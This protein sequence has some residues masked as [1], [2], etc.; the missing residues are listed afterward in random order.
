MPA[1]VTKFR[2]PKAK[3]PK[4][5]WR[6]GAL[7]IFVRDGFYHARGT[8]RHAGLKRRVRASLEIPYSREIPEAAK[9]AARDLEEKIRGELGGGVKP[10]SAAEVALGFMTRP[11]DKPLGATDIAAVKELVRHFGTRILRDIAPAEFITFVDERQKG[12]TSSGRERYLNAVHAL[13]NEAIRKGQ[14]PKM[15]AFNRDKAARNP[16]RRARRKVANVRP[17]LVSLLLEASHTSIA[18]QLCAEAATGARVSSVLFG[19]TLDDLVM[20]PGAMQITYHDTKNGDDVTSALPESARPVLEVFLAW[21]E[22]QVRAGRVSAAGH[23]PL[24]L[25]PLG[26]PYKANRNYTGTRNKTGF[27]AAKRRAITLLKM[28]VAETIA[29]C[30]AAG[31]VVGAQQARKMLAEDLA[32]LQKVTQHWLRHKLATELGRIDLRAAMRQGGWRDVRSVQGYLT[33]DAEFQRGAVENRILFDTNLTRE[34][35]SDD[36]K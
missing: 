13:L 22:L 11:K 26:R 12:N 21:R 25:T 32:I 8:V 36:S 34:E 14:Y 29:A 15:P 10:L 2:R 5:T 9:A 23:A 31:D 33:D 17:Y 30:E 16:T 1:A 18:A 4:S 6:E 3:S 7:V 24:F 19:C 20:K 27:R 35:P 28:R